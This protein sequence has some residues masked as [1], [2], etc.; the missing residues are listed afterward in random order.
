MTDASFGDLGKTVWVGI[1]HFGQVVLGG[2][3]TFYGL[4]ENAMDLIE[5]TL[6]EAKGKA[7]QR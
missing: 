6:D 4:D 3:I 1:S 7:A 2:S 5:A